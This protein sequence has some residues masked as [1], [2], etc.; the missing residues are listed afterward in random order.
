M[1]DALAGKIAMV[2]GASRG[3]GRAVAHKLAA[4]G[5]D[6]VLVETVGVGQAEVEVASLAD[7]TLVLLAPGMG[8]A[9]QAVA[10]DLADRAALAADRVER[11]RDVGRELRT[12]GTMDDAAKQRAQSRHQ[13]QRDPARPPRPGGF[14]S[15]RSS[16]CPRSSWSWPDGCSARRAG[17]FARRSRPP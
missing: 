4:A 12:P 3:I 16:T 11:R 13:R 10:C 14:S 9:I 8:D 6:V 15:P 7:T 5:C 17:C 1:S 2:T